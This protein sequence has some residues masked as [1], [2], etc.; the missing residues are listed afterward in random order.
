MKTNQLVGCV[1]LALS[2]LTTVN[3]APDTQDGIYLG[4]TY[5]NV[6]VKSGG[7]T[8]L[9]LGAVSATLGTRFNQ[10]FSMELRAGTGVSDDNFGGAMFE[11]ESVLGLHLMGTFQLPQTGLSL[12]G[13]IGHSRV[14]LTASMNGLTGSADEQGI[15]YGTGLLYATDAISYRAGYE[16][17]LKK[18]GTSFSGLTA[19]VYLNF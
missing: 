5:N 4:A 11:I 13:S 1:V 18:S 12:Y 14:D 19:G 9:T 15:S 6:K 3:A 16:T 2:G 8:G 10:H 7:E 17:L